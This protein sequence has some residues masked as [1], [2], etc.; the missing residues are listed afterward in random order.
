M[1]MWLL[2]VFENDWFCLFSFILIE[3]F[4][5]IPQMPLVFT[6]RCCKFVLNY[7]LP[8]NDIDLTM[9]PSTLKTSQKVFYF[10]EDDI[11]EH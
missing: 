10:R 3:C 2:L 7:S 5:G 8:D 6:S 9:T 1:L 4:L 11:A